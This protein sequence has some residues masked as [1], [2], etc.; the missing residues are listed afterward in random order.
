MEHRY[1]IKERID[2]HFTLWR[3]AVWYGR[4]FMQYFF[5]YYS[6]LEKPGL[7]GTDRVHLAQKGKSIFSHRLAKQMKKALN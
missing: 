3:M 5:I 7:L 2:Q 4:V 6:L 1:K